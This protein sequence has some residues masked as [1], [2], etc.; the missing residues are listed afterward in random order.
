V[1][2]GGPGS[3]SADSFPFGRLTQRELLDVGRLQAEIL[4][5]RRVPRHLL[6]KARC[7]T[8]KTLSDRRRGRLHVVRVGLFMHDGVRSLRPDRHHAGYASSDVARVGAAPNGRLMATGPHRSPRASSRAVYGHLS[9]PNSQRT[10]EAGRPVI[11]GELICLRASLPASRPVPLSVS[12]FKRRQGRPSTEL[13]PE[14]KHAQYAVPI[15]TAFRKRGQNA[16]L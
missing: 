14:R 16:R 2:C 6:S 8:E 5:A 7:R 1:P 3:A 15:S 13:P 4:Q 11:Q 9:P 10:I 12:Y